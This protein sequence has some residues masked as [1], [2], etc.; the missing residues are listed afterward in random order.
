MLLSE[1]ATYT[2]PS[3]SIAIPSGKLNW[4]TAVPREPHFMIKLPLL[5]NFS[6]LLFSPKSTT[7]TLF[8]ESVVIPDGLV[9]RPEPKPNEPH[10]VIKVPLLVNF[11][12]WFDRLVKL[13]I[14]ILSLESIAIP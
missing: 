6:T 4:P 14:W 5:S 3:E 13:V 7:Y 9:K 12:I 2:L 1:S 11:S 8:K 10:D